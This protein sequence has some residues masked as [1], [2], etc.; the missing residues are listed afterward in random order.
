MLPMFVAN[1][2][3]GIRDMG[4]DMK[5]ADIRL[6]RKQIAD[7]SRIGPRTVATGQILDG[8]PTPASAT[9]VVVRTT[10]EGREAVR[11]LKASGADFIKV[12]SWLPRDVYFA[13]GEE[14]KRQDMPFAGHLPMSITALEAS[15][16]GQKSIEH[17]SGV[18]LAVRP[19]RK[20]SEASC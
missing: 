9:F 18:D 1:G 14:A 12:Y 4:T 20:R 2:V 17:L 10:D 6:L 13:I 15:D 7:G 3:L 8:R 11:S 16:A 19:V 5:A